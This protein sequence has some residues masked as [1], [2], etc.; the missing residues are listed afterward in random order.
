MR[1]DEPDENQPILV[2]DMRDQ[3]TVVAAD[4]KNDANA[5]NVR[6]TPTLLHIRKVPPL[7]FLSDGIP[8]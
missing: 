6:A 7:R 2:I 4:I 3:S 8:V 1:Q 5:D